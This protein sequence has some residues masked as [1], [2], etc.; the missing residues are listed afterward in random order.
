VALN[1][2]IERS[3][4]LRRQRGRIVERNSCREPMSHTTIAGVRHTFRVAGRELEA[5]LDLFNVLNLINS[6]WGL[7]RASDPQLLEHVE[8]TSDP[9]EKAKPVF[10]FNPDRQQWAPA[11]ESAYQ[12]QAGLRYRF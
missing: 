4:C 7:Y 6:R 10:R 9:P 11:P 3:K 5:G 2:F 8:Q 12:L 1:R